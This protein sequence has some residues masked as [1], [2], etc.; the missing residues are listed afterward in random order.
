[1]STDENNKYK[2]ISTR[3]LEYQ[4]N[5]QSH[6]YP[7]YYDSI[8]LHPKKLSFKTLEC[9]GLS[10]NMC[11]DIKD[12]NNLR[13]CRYNFESKECETMPE[14]F[15][16]RATFQIGGNAQLKFYNTVPKKL[17]LNRFSAFQ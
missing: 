11:V 17:D 14:Q 9:E 10:Y 5:L 13:K 1:M 8:N 4:K 12:E 7:K 16:E 2:S 3:I 15:R 6:N